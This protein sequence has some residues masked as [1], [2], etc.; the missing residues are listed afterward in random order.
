MWSKSQM[1]WIEALPAEDVVVPRGLS[2]PV[3][4]CHPPIS[5][6]AKYTRTLTACSTSVHTPAKYTC[7]LTTY[8]KSIHSL[9]KYTCT[10]TTFA[11]VSLVQTLTKYSGTLTACSTSTVYIHWLNTHAHLQ[12]VTRIIHFILGSKVTCS[13]NS[14]HHTFVFL[15]NHL[16][17]FLS[18]QRSAFR[19]YF[20]LV[21]LKYISLLLTNILHYVH[22]P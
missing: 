22:V 9:A 3:S 1:N 5:T 7:T 4:L 20:I 16:V 21:N 12:H 11:N 17:D 8:S 19:P 6:P 15:P 10:L 18:L 14:F 13:S 2:V